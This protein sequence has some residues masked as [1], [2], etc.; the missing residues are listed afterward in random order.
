MT[1]KM[2]LNLFNE[3]NRVTFLFKE[4]DNAPLIVF[5]VIFGLLIFLE[6]IGAIFTGWIKRTLVTPEFTFNFIGLEWLQP[7][8]GNGM[9]FYY[10]F[11]GICGFLVMLGYRY[12]LSLSVFTVMWTATYLMQKASYN[13]HY[14]LLILVCAMMLLLPANRYL[15]LDVKRKPKTQKLSM[16]NWCIVIIV[17]QLWIV[18]TYASIAKMYPD[19]LDT[20]AVESL[21]AS[22]KNYPVIGEYMTSKTLHYFVAYTGILFD[23]LVVPLLLWKPTRNLALLAS[24][25]FHIFN[26]IV[27]Q[28]GIFPFLSLAFIVFFYPPETIRRVFLKKK[29]ALSTNETTHLKVPKNK[30]VFISLAVIYF[31]IQ[32]ALPLRHWLIKGDVLWTEEGHRMSWRMMLRTKSGYISFK[33][34]DKKTGE[35]TFIRPRDFLS[36]K[37][38]GMITSKPD[39]I[40]QFAQRIKQKEAAKGRD[41]AVYAIGKTR[42]NSGPLK[43]LID[44]ETDLAAEKWNHFS[45]HEWILPYEVTEKD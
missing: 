36:R 21:L 34:V 19:W 43:T 30:H 40:W 44:P 23:L 17:L 22:K 6:S 35:T 2:H 31:C 12:R 7:L 37:Q 45:H 26:A 29:P 16:P 28:I 24:F 13:N 41:V 11:M 20:S 39:V 14:Y 42:V 15:S 32:I 10:A 5:R 9:Y 18:Y 25:I 33:V 4:V 3:E 1:E 38:S 8:P 27:F